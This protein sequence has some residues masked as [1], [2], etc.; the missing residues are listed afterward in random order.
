MLK[1][2]AY[3]TGALCAVSSLL[4]VEQPYLAPALNS[5]YTFTPL[6][7]VAEQVQLTGGGPSDKFAFVGIPDA[8]GLYKDTVT[9]ENILFVAHELGSTTVTEPL[10]GQAKFKGSF[11]SRYVLADSTA[12][13][14]SGGVAHDDLYFG[15][16]LQQGTPILSSQSGNGFGRFCSGSFAGPA[17]G[18]DRPIFLTNEES[19]N[20]S[21]LNS[22]GSQ[23]VAIIDGNLHTV[24]AL[25]R[26]ARETTRI[27]PRRDSLTAVISTED[28]GSTSFVYLYVGTKQRKN[29]NPLAKNG[30][31]GGKIYVLA[32]RGADAGKTEATF[33]TGVMTG[34]LL[35]RWVEIS[36]AAALTDTQLNAAAVAA[37]GYSFVRVEDAEFDPLAPTKTIFLGV[38]GGS[39][40]NTLGRLYKVNFNALDPK[41][42]GSMDLIYNSQVVHNPDGDTIGDNLGNDYN[43]G[44]D[45]PVSIDNIAVTAN[46]IVVCEDRNSP[47]NAIFTK[48]NRNG[49]VW[50]LDR[51]N[52]YAAKLQATFNYAAI[53][54]RGDTAPT[55][56]GLWEASGVID[57][58]SIYGAGAFLINVQG[59]GTVNSSIPNFTANYAEDGQVLLVRPVL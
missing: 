51:N 22:N 19:G 56:K 52:N 4:A 26:V 14:I 37:G 35:T 16:A 8:M 23:T 7:T 13:V 40:V 2:I 48:Y 5:D 15:N 12:A 46:H 53:S 57:A 3:T 36:N 58:S 30:L 41:A 39:G 42:D 9:G 29:A 25:G 44:T 31:E 33:G 50:T 47:A 20:T 6:V 59:H 34:S 18:F 49:G 43:D 28:G 55:D 11:V 45:Y 1:F 24:P 32:G 10:P 21:T 54:A 38:T 27:M 17:E